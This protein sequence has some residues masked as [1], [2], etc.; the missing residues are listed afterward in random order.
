MANRTPFP[1]DVVEAYDRLVATIP[2][3]E[4]RG[5]TMPYT[6]VNGNMFSF[7]TAEGTVALRL[8]AS[9][10]EALE[11]KHHARPVEQHGRVM[12]E[13]VEVPASLLSDAAEMARLFAASY[14][15]AS[16]LKPKKTGR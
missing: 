10:R 15:Y 4:R 1:D 5:A 12:K 14:Q 8:P 6:S 3:V 7:L 9:E 11:L 2:D 13:Y 16:A